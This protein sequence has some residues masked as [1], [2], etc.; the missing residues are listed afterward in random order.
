[1][2]MTHNDR[3]EN[4]HL[5]TSVFFHFSLIRSVGYLTLGLSCLGSD[6]ALTR[7]VTTS[8]AHSSLVPL[9]ARVMALRW[10]LAHIPRWTE[11]HMHK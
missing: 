5:F 4:P 2:Q 7:Y 3:K 1:M 9:P 6:P 11:G 10:F 8:K